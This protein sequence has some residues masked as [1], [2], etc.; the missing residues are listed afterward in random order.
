[1]I[2]AQCGAKQV[3]GVDKSTII[4]QAVDIV[5]SAFLY[6]VSMQSDVCYA[7]RENGLHDV[8]TLIRGRIE[9]V[10]LPTEKVNVHL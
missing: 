3:I 7:G 9:D 1:M 5:M 6:D 8:V 4:H 2:A 10:Q